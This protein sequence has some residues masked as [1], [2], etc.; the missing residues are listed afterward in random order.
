[1]VMV[2]ALALCLSDFTFGMILWTFAFFVTHIATG[3]MD[4][5]IR[6]VVGK[7]LLFHISIWL[8]LP[9]AFAMFVLE[10][11]NDKA[12]ENPFMWVRAVVKNPLSYFKQYPKNAK[13]VSMSLAGILG[14][15]LWAMYGL[16]IVDLD[17]WWSTIWN[18]FLFGIGSCVIY[19][20][21]QEVSE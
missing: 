2:K 6:W 13:T 15:A 20:I 12:S 14:A 18:V 19:G 9:V 5:P 11:G 16:K 4:F 8:S 3:V 7:P 21:M 10:Y 17:R 1:M